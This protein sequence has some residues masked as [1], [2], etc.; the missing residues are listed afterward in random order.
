MAPRYLPDLVWNSEGD[1]RRRTAII[2]VNG[3]ISYA[4]LWERVGQTVRQ[5]RAVGV[6][7]GDHVGLYVPRSAE[8]VT[9]L[10]AVTT[11]GAVAVPMDPE[12][13]LDR[14]DAMC[15]AARPRVV[16]HTDV[17]P[18]ADT[19]GLPW[20]A[21]DRSRERGGPAAVDEVWRE[22]AADEQPALILFTS[23]S[24]GRP[25]G[26]V[27]HHEGLANRL[28]WGHRVYGFDATD[29]VLHKA[30]IAFDAAIHEIFA[31]LVAGGTLV[32]APPGLQ[33]D[34]GG[35]VRLIRETEATCAHFVPSVLRYVLDEEELRYC[36][37]LRLMYCGGE[38]LDMRMVRRLRGLLGCRV[39]NLY[40][41]T[42]TSVNATTWDASEPF[43][44]DIAP[45]GRPIDGVTC[46][47]L[48]ENLAPLPTGRTGELWIGGVGLSL[49]Y[50]DA[51]ALT[52][53]RYLPDPWRAGRLYRTGDL[54]RLTPQGYLE[55]RGRVDD[56]VKVRG[57]RVEPEGVSTALRQHP[58]VHDAV[59]V[60]APDGEGG[61]HL[62]AYVAAR[63]AHSPVVDGLRRIRL[64]NG[65][66]VA[67]PSPDETLFLYR[68]VFEENEYGRFGIRVTPG[69]VVV[70][71]GANLGL[72]SLWAH[73]QAPGIRIVSV[74]PNPDVLP[75]LRANLELNDVR[76]QVVPAA[77]T[78]RV[79]KTTLTSFPGLTYLSGI[80]EQRGAQAADLVRS[81]FAHTPVGSAGATELATLR[82]DAE[83]RLRATVH[84]VPTI[85]LSTV[86][87]EHDVTRVDLL[88]INVE[89]AESGVLRGVRPEHWARVRQ[90]CMEVE[91]GS[92]AIPPIAALLR[93]AGFTVHTQ[94]DWAVGRDADVS[95]VYA[96]RDSESPTG[97]PRGTVAPRRELLT[98]REIHRHT[99]E[100]LP[101]AMRPSHI[102]FVEDLPRL[103]NGKVSRHD[104]PPADL[105]APGDVGAG[106]GAAP[107]EA[108][109]EIW[110]MVLAMDRIND[111]DD[112]VSLGGHSLL[113]LR[114]SARVRE[115]IGVETSPS[116]CL[117]AESFAQWAA[118]LLRAADAADA[119]GA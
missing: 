98:A 36:T 48:D 87:D 79:G 7:P 52:A 65:L 32:I 38:A 83:E 67:T 93:E 80:G 106:T 88:K 16:L 107:R 54:A 51:P 25:K 56:Q 115:A 91:N 90:V 27:L 42:E 45:I 37:S 1:D 82:Q 15:A 47:V 111:D 59:V 81:H 41:P 71:V 18:P 104:L 57:V 118:E 89:G 21:L 100:V 92:V 20:L 39:V 12:F 46:H 76:A 94:A 23:G 113:A 55:F 4:Q 84:T 102:V 62:V 22:R 64:P 8:Y 13:P 44:G 99:A 60:G 61:L 112:F 5:L 63:R 14:L 50:L 17:E 26:V 6:C 31:P 34:S 108:L 29:R 58:L 9:S 77:V 33:F 73:E 24:T 86:L 69:D 95:Y 53:E 96:T 116:R 66:P 105:P 3:E 35:L 119:V 103:P 10:L 30:S 109:R 75:Y 72:F 117:R 101:Q 97:V 85:D 43:D 11:I 40:G 70:D 114:V 49:G 28:E 2:D 74:E 19:T 110:R 68:Q 78:D